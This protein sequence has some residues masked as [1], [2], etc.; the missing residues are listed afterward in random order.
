MHTFHF[1]IG[2]CTVTFENMVHI[3]GLPINEKVIT[4][5][6]K[7][8]CVHQCRDIQSL[9]TPTSIETYVRCHIV[10]L[11]GT[12]LFP[13][14]STAAV[15][16]KYLPLLRNLSTIKNYSWGSACLMH[17]YRFYS[18]HHDTLL[19]SVMAP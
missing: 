1:F 16:S 2:K 14:K 4:I 5:A 18:E 8:A 7:L 19:R 10:Y 9:D 3:F 13:D 11:L 17:M 12:L 15:N 6:I